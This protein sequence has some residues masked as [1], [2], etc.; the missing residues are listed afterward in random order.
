MNIYISNELLIE[1]C[2]NKKIKSYSFYSRLLVFS[3]RTL[4]WTCS[5]SE[6]LTKLFPFHI[7]SREIQTVMQK[8]RKSNFIYRNAFREQNEERFGGVV[9]LCNTSAEVGNT[10]VFYFS[11]IWSLSKRFVVVIM[12]WIFHTKTEAEI[13]KISFAHELFS[14]SEHV[15]K[16]SSVVRFLK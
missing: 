10:T 1:V 15:I 11:R 3:S 9:I 2:Q 13:L 14:H 6:L 12:R 4:H 5:S 8:L 16:I 7:F